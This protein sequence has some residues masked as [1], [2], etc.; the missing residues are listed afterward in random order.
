[1]GFEIGYVGRGGIRG[2]MGRSAD[3]GIFG[4]DDQA[5][6]DFCF[7][8]FA[9]LDDIGVRESDLFGVGVSLLDRLGLLENTLWRL[10]RA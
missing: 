2:V 6:E 8:V 10:L 3:L 1:M 5:L 7:K 9:M 4:Q